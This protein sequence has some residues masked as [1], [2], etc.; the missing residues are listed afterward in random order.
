MVLYYL[1]SIFLGQLGL[2]HNLFDYASDPGYTY[3]D[4]NGFGH[5][6]RG[7]F[8]FDAYWTVC[9]LLLLLAAYLMWVSGLADNLPWRFAVA[10]RRFG[11]SQKALAGWALAA[12]VA[13][14]GFIL[15]NTNVL[16]TFRSRTT[17]ERLTVRYE[18]DYRK[19]LNAPLPRITSV[20]YQA[21]IFPER[22]AVRFH[23]KYG[24]TNKTSQ[25]VDRI[26]VSV[27]EVA[28]IRR[29]EFNIPARQEIADRP[30]NLLIYRFNP[31]LTPGASGELAFDLEYAVVGFQ[32]DGGSTALVYN[33]TF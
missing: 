4:I 12:L 31:P 14:G 28:T 2:E 23:G 33:G 6:L 27:P 13:I 21:D 19:Y 1:S 32:N 26:L 22:L 7:L 29:L 15:Y 8:W 20:T 5:W 10:R 24:F 3:S 17:T 16:H 30:V 18:H 9:A 11:P 25:P